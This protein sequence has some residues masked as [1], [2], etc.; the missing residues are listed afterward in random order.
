MWYLSI[1][2]SAWTEGILIR[3]TPESHKCQ[4][5]PLFP[6][7]YKNLPKLDIF[8]LWPPDYTGISETSREPG[9]GCPCLHAEGKPKNKQAKSDIFLV[10]IWQYL[11]LKT[12]SST[13]WGCSL[14]I[15]VKPERVWSDTEELLQFNAATILPPP[16]LQHITYGYQR[17]ISCLQS[18]QAYLSVTYILGSVLMLALETG[19]GLLF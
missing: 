16:N 4:S 12:L 3:N 19:Q 17:Y 8:L 2:H 5:S 1:Y 13:K 11:M 7:I 18:C 6:M 14:C 10:G 15:K 9:T